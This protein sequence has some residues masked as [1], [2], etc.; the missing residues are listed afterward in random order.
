M[1]DTQKVP[2]ATIIAQL[3]N[4]N[5]DLLAALAQDKADIAI[6]KGEF[7]ELKQMVKE[8]D[9]EI[10]FTRNH[11]AKIQHGLNSLKKPKRTSNKQR[12]IENTQARVRELEAELERAKAEN[13]QLQQSSEHYK[14]L[15]EASQAESLQRQNKVE[16]LEALNANLGMYTGQQSVDTPPAEP[17][18][19][20]VDLAFS[21]GVGQSASPYNANLGM[22]TGQQ[23]VDTPPAE[24]QGGDIDP[25]FAMG[26]GQS[27]T[28]Q[29]Q[30]SQVAQVPQAAQPVQYGGVMNQMPTMGQTQPYN[31]QQ[32]YMPPGSNPW[33]GG[34][35]QGGYAQ[36]GYA[37]GGYNYGYGFQP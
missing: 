19:G 7:E 3:R 34:Y 37:Q 33:Q 15:Y 22:C 5:A 21:M 17:Q 2:A 11:A 9:A 28:P 27:V 29:A 25:A 26:V 32:A 36:G 6:I 10:E 20:D 31:Y 24:P 16:Q 4:H 13:G 35:A 8:R 30:A 1:A 12:E 14:Q 23:S 18:G